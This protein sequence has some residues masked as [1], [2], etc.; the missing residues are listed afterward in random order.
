MRA[1]CGDPSLSCVELAQASTPAPRNI[2]NSLQRVQVQLRH[3]KVFPVV[4]HQR[5]AMLQRDRGDDRVGQGEGPPLF[6][7]L[8]FESP[9]NASRAG[10]CV[11]EE[12]R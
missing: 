9:G 12:R 11:N 7:P 6:R 1:E 3:R 4:G 8:T 5:A 2:G 10:G